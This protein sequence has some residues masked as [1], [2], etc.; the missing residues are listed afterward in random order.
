MSP[1]L[2]SAVLLR[3]FILLVVAV[4]CVRPHCCKA[5]QLP[6]QTNIISNA[7]LNMSVKKEQV[8]KFSSDGQF[9]NNMT[10]PHQRLWFQT[11]L[12]NQVVHQ[13][14]GYW[15]TLHFSDQGTGSYM[16]LMSIL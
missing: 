14:P 6:V 10:C 1:T 8:V 3:V 13:G 7:I 4:F 2:N 12:E 5:T 9:H 16:N 11:V 15:L